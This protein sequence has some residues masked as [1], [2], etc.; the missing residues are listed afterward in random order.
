[1]D[2]LF[3]V[4]L[5]VFLVIGIGYMAAWRKLLSSD[6]VDGLLVFAQNFAIPCLLFRAIWEM[7]L[8]ANFEAPLLISYFSGTFFAFVLGWAGTLIIFKRTMQEAIVLGFVAMFSSSVVLGLSITERAFGGHTLGPNFA[9]VALHAPFCYFWGVTCM[10]VAR[11]DGKGWSKNAVSV[12]TTIVQNP[13]VIAIVLGVFANLLELQLP[14]IAIGGLD[15]M[16]RAALPTA[17]FALGG[18]LFRYRP[19][20]DLVQVA[21]ICTIS[22][23]AQPLV[24]WGLSAAVFDLGVEPAQ[25]AVLTAAMAPAVNGFLFANMY[26]VAKRVAATSVLVGTAFSILTVSVWLFIIG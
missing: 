20:G 9:I 8:A 24:V 6:G 17:L 4:S 5:P 26:G 14:R 13:L 22:L 16:I 2:I 19:E 7:D 21:F 15:L 11:S 1:M 3:Y 23:C 12:S 18:I 25:S 10:E